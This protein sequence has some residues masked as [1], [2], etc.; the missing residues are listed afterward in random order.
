MGL[1]K[2][3]ISL[4]VVLLNPAPALS[5]PLLWGP[6]AGSLNGQGAIK[7]RATLVVCPVSLVSQ[8][9]DGAIDKTKDGTLKVYQYYGGKRTTDPAILRDNDIVITTYQVLVSDMNARSGFAKAEIA[10][11]GRANY[12][13]PLAKLGFWRIILDES[14]VIKEANTAMA[15]A[16]RMLSAHRRWCVSGTPAPLSL[17]NL[18]SPRTWAASST[19]WASGPRPSRSSGG[20]RSGTP[21]SSG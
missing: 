6:P 13:P 7:T 15:K 8:W 2:T 5:S 14:H 4:A 3:I 19:S 21:R 12:V 10:K 16:V 17:E 18:Q 9:Y 11:K 20:S 1:G